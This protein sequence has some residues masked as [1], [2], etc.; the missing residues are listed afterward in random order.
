MGFTAFKAFVKGGS[1]LAQKV[2]LARLEG[3]YE[4]KKSLGVAK[5]K[6]LAENVGKQTTFQAGNVNLTFTDSGL[7]SQPERTARNISDM[8]TVLGKNKYQNFLKAAKKLP[9]GQTKVSNLNNHLLNITSLWVDGTAKEEKIGDVAKVVKHEDI[10]IP[11]KQTLSSGFGEEFIKNVVAPA[12]NVSYERFQKKYPKK[13][14]FLSDKKLTSDGYVTYNHIPYMT[15]DFYNSAD[16]KFIISQANYAAKKLGKNLSYS[17]LLARWQVGQGNEQADAPQQKKVWQIFSDLR[18]AIGPQGID[19]KNPGDYL[20][21]IYKARDDAYSIGVQPSQFSNMLET[22][23]LPISEETDPYIYT[24][25]ETRDAIRDKQRENDVERKYGIERKQAAQKKSGATG[26]SSIARAMVTEI[27][28]I[29][30]LNE[31]QSG[32]SQVVVA[33]LKQAWEGVFGDSGL[34]SGLKTFTTWKNDREIA[35]VSP[36]A[37]ARLDARLKK[38]RKMMRSGKEEDEI[39]G[40]IEF[41]KFNLAYNMASAFQGGTGGRTISDQDIENMMAAMNFGTFGSEDKVISTLTTIQGIMRDVSNIQDG[42]LKGGKAASVSYLLEKTNEAF[43][44]DY[45]GTG[46]FA[47]YATRKLK[48]DKPKSRFNRKYTTKEVD[49]PNF[50]SSKA[51]SPTNPKTIFTQV[52]VN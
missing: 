48:G 46:N 3:E 9:D 21:F 12:Y 16:G 19:P 15:E 35:S 29:R 50:D 37:R 20:R 24:S 11:Y 39:L 8:F 5:A 31:G 44:V 27:E 40:R 10:T 52:P 2:A 30:T 22:F 36:A 17:D 23:L 38:A 7:K 32:G 13:L 14:G 26:A 45:K 33:N 43:G 25:L 41:M 4:L 6:T 51:E 1:E 42:Y 49:N 28:K 34:F 47:D 18:Y